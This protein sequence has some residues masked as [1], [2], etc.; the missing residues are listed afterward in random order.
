ME[1]WSWWGGKWMIIRGCGHF[2]ASLSQAIW[3][4]GRFRLHCDYSGKVIVSKP[5]LW[6]WESLLRWNQRH[7]R[8]S[9]WSSFFSF[10]LPSLWSSWCPCV[11]SPC[12][13][14]PCLTAALCFAPLLSS[15]DRNHVR[16]Q[17]MPSLRA[18]PIGRGPLNACR[19]IKQLC[20]A[21][22]PSLSAGMGTCPTLISSKGKWE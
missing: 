9:R 14:L 13:L 20:A 5:P 1:G 16:E 2:L 19:F 17:L 18:E 11:R 12:C 8:V 22:T 3:V 21:L 4:F 6:H 15:K 10:A 7:P